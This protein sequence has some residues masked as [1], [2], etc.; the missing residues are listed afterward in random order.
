[1]RIKSMHHT[2]LLGLLGLAFSITAVLP[3]FASTHWARMGTD[4]VAVAR[5][6]STWHEVGT[7][8]TLPL[9][10]NARLDQ[11][12]AAAGSWWAT[13][14]E[15]GA[16]ADRLVLL[17]GDGTSIESLSTPELGAD[18]V[19]LQPHLIVGDDGLRFLVW[20]E[21]EDHQKTLVRSARWT[22]VG[23]AEPVTVSP[24]G[25][26]TQIA[27]QAVSLAD[28]TVLATWSSF[29]GEDDEI[30]WSLLKDG[31][32]SGPKAI[33]ANDVPDVTPSLRS[34]GDGAM[35]VW[36]GY[37]GN[38]YRIFSAVFSGGEW[39]K[40]DSFGGRGSILPAFAD[41][42]EPLVLFQQTSPK[43]WSF[44]QMND[45]GRMKRQGSIEYRRQRPV[46]VNVESTGLNVLW[47]GHKKAADGSF[48][49][50]TALSRVPWELV[51][52]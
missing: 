18:G 44:V 1:M 34:F 4:G 3:A 22:G 27:L 9:T 50:G 47:V 5:L 43:A 48:E 24:R 2:F 45:R 15:P 6:D 40:A 46:P 7:G 25:Q 14:V 13:A 17:R 23:W 49:L 20:I 42:P 30:V 31:K 19:L 11:F 10:R 12:V 36:S 38:D 37:D 32:W 39:S 21:G 28:D 33:S 41:T 16:G 52:E 8:R 51:S 26:G 29:D 35:V